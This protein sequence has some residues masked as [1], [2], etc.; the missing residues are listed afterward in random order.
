M[1]KTKK[2]T[3]SAKKN[4]SEAAAP[5]GVESRP[6]VTTETSRLVGLSIAAVVVAVVISFAPLTPLIVTAPLV[7]VL[8]KR[9][10]TA[11]HGAVTGMTVRW[12]ISVFLTALVASAFVPDRVLDSFPYA[13]RSA[14]N[15]RSWLTGLS[16]GSPAGYSYILGGMAA[17]VIASVVSA[18]VLGCVLWS[19]GLGTCAAAAS[20]LYSQGI[21]VVQITLVAVPPWQI[22]L[23]AA[24]LFALAP[25]AAFSRRH[26]F[27]RG[28]DDLEWQPLRRHVY[29]AAGLFVLSLLLR[30]AVAGPYLALVRRWTIA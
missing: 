27:R 14:E 28:E 5:E 17:F 22:A 26:V 7:P 1:A 10:R 6:K 21:N 3:K 19:I 20:Y 16:S 24:G 9:S 8:F 23:F 12:V 25:A 18:G 2:Q 11:R 13:V 15:V 4:R 30:L 29:V